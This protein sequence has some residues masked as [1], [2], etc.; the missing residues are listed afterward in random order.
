MHAHAQFYVWYP[1]SIED[2]GVDLLTDTIHYTE[3]GNKQY[4]VSIDKETNTGIYIYYYSRSKYKVNPSICTKIWYRIE[5]DTTYYIKEKAYEKGGK[6]R[7]ETNW[8]KDCT[9]A[10]V[11]YHYN[12]IV[13]KFNRTWPEKLYTGTYEEIHG[14][15]N[16]WFT[17]EYKND[18]RVGKWTEYHYNGQKEME[19]KYEK[20]YRK[21]HIQSHRK[22]WLHW[23]TDQNQDT[24]FQAVY[25][26]YWS[27]PELP[28]SMANHGMYMNAFGNHWP[29]RSY[30][31]HGKWNFWS[32]SGK[33]YKFE[34]YRHGYLIKVGYLD[35]LK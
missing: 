22:G 18:F 29:G 4:A 19:G 6:L 13:Y 1:T 20:A 17:G 32:E 26:N 25:R 2:Y 31:R 24:V 16:M 12:S 33:R 21:H 7:S 27:Y 3:V 14:N 23:I 10:S 15:G 9:M 11:E 28:D 34:V 35:T 5:G 8:N 30:N